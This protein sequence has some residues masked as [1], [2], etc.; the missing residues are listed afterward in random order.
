MNKKKLSVTILV[1]SLY[2]MGMVGISP[3][4]QK[5]TAAF[6][7]ASELAAQLAS[8]F[9]SLMMVAGALLAGEASLRLGRRKTALLG[10]G[11]VACAGAGGTLLCASLA[12]VFVWAGLLGLG[13]GLFVPAANSMLV[14]RFAPEE[15]GRI[16]GLQST[17]V[18]VGGVLLS[19]FAGLLAGVRWNLAFLVY[20]GALSGLVLGFRYLPKEPKTPRPAGE[21]RAPLPAYALLGTAQT[22]LFAVVYFCFNT[23]AALLLAQRG[24]SSSALAG[25]AT[26][27]FMAGGAVCGLLF[28]RVN[29]AAGAHMP[30][31]ALVLVAAG[32]VIIVGCRGMAAVC[33]GAMIAGGSL[34]FIFPYFVV[35]MGEHIPPESLVLSTS[36]IISVGPNLGSFVS[37]LILTNLAA[38]LGH[39]D[40]EFRLIL[41][42]AFAL[43]LA[44]VLELCGAY[45]T[46]RKARPGGAA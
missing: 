8:T 36:L 7:D 14:D 18:N 41:A 37:P 28:Q 29:R 23:N 31:L 21:K 33:L 20:L 13:V 25:V 11:L 2:Q 43:L 6:P 12:L 16:T 15:R 34:S 5:L 39:D 24:L 46:R 44:A 32:Y 9:P 3:I 4:V 38:Y 1:L 10:T 22:F 19:L 42:A 26:A 40:V 45:G 35:H 30:S 27:C 17:F